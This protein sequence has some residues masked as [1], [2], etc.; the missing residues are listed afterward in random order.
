MSNER[1]PREVCSMTIGMRGL[2]RLLLA[3]GGPQFRLCLGLF[4]VRC[5]DCLTRRSLLGRN[6]LDL[7]RDPVECTRQ[8]NGLA[9]RLVGSGLLRLVEDLVG[10]LEAVAERL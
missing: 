2:I 3:S 6:P 10:L 4:L 7:V 9:L 8:P 1:S 5:P